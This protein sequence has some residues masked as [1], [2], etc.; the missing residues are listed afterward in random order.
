MSEEKICKCGHLFVDHD[1]EKNENPPPVWE[2]PCTKCDVCRYFQR[3]TTIENAKERSQR[4]YAAWEAQKQEK[5][6]FEKEQKE[7]ERLEKER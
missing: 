1:V 3:P 5:E 6:R 4:K 7:K 2:N